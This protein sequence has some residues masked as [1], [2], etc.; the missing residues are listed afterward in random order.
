MIM[1]LKRQAE[2]P[3]KKAKK[4]S[5][6]IQKAPKMPP[7][8]APGGLRRPLATQVGAWS[9]PAWPKRPRNDAKRAPRA[10]Q[11]RLAAKIASENKPGDH[12][13]GSARN[14]RAS[15][16]AGKARAARAGRTARDGAPEPQRGARREWREPPEN[17]DSKPVRSLMP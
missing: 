1:F 2:N 12:G 3:S 13:T 9:L 5:K 15:S 16:I 8:I 10:T 4:Q 14:G 17:R 7:K 6:I 11:E